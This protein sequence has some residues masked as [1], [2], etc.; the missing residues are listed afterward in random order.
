[1]LITFSETPLQADSPLLS[2][3]RIQRS[4]VGIPASSGQEASKARTWRHALGRMPALDSEIVHRLALYG[5]AR[6]RSTGAPHAFR[7]PRLA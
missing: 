7:L 2:N 1:M 6:L 5:P 4:S 3:R